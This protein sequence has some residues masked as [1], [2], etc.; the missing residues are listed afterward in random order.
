M[1]KIVSL[2]RISEIIST[3]FSFPSRNFA[4]TDSKVSLASN[5]LH[6]LNFNL[7]GKL[8]EHAQVWSSSIVCNFCLSFL[9][10]YHSSVNVRLYQ[11]SP[12]MSI[13]KE[14]RLR[15]QYFQILELLFSIC[16][17]SYPPSPSSSRVNSTGSYFRSL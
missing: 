15:C 1:Q 5:S 11:E 6:F 17:I 14:L 2:F 7:K 4:L 9:M 10:K 8:T 13:A 3:F 12:R 16:A